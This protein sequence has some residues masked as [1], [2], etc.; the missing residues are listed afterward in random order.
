MQADPHRELSWVGEEFVAH[1]KNARW[2]IVLG[3]AGLLVTLVIYLAT[4]DKFTTGIIIFTAIAFGLFAARKPKQQSYR[5]SGQD[6]Q[7]GNKSYGLHDF[8]SF[9]ADDEGGVTSVVFMPLKRFM[10]PLTIY[11]PQNIEHD[12]TS[13]LTAFLPFEARKADAVDSLMRR[14]HF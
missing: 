8:K 13:Y 5:L 6:L 1:D 2:F 9:S 10:P 14:I 4:K 11:V 7:V 3:G 12:V